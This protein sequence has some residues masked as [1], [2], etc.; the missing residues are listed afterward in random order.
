M[1]LTVNYSCIPPIFLYPFLSDS[2]ESLSPD[3]CR[4]TASD[5]PSAHQNCF[6]LSFDAV[7]VWPSAVV[8]PSESA[9]FRSR[10]VV[11]RVPR[12][13]GAVETSHS[14][15]YR[16]LLSGLVLHSRPHL[17]HLPAAAVGRALRQSLNS[18]FESRSTS[19]EC[20]WVVV[21]C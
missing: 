4:H 18:A 2:P 11:D 6:R 20:S 9:S 17:R 13:R 21:L 7:T 1:C 8:S 14:S 12:F 5:P 10:P 16:L 3:W 19:I 15:F